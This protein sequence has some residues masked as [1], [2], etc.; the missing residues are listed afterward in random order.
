VLGAAFAA[1][2]G[3]LDLSADVDRSE[4]FVRAEVRRVAG[5][6]DLGT[7]QSDLT[8]VALTNPVFIV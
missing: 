1:D 3:S 2:D 5:S 7:Y 6:P 8:M 4:G